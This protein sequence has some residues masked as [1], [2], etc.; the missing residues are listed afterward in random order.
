M[1]KVEKVAAEEERHFVF[2]F[3]KPLRTD[4]GITSYDEQEDAQYSAQLCM[5]ETTK[6]QKYYQH[7][8]RKK[9]SM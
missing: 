1:K 9:K 8:L 6:K 5:R 2:V 4:T 7:V 3:F